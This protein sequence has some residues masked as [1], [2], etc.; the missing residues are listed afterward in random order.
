[1]QDD[2]RRY[3]G[4]AGILFTEVELR[5]LLVVLQGGSSE[6]RDALAHRINGYLIYLDATRHIEQYADKLDYR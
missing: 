3:Y 4:P 1:M 6:L 2:D 5:Q